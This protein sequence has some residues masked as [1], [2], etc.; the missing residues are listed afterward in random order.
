MRPKTRYLAFGAT[1][2]GEARTAPLEG[3][4]AG[5]AESVVYASWRWCERSPALNPTNRR[6]RTRMSG[7]V[8]GEEPRGSPLSRFN[9]SR[10]SIPPSS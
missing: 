3:T 10:A 2:K 4:E 8:G 6:I 1:G 7:G 9:Q 5:A